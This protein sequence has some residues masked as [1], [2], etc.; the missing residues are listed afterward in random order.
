M[1]P[2]ELTRYP[3]IVFDSIMHVYPTSLRLA[4]H[5]PWIAASSAIASA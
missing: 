5:R 3:I 1:V 2:V 4:A